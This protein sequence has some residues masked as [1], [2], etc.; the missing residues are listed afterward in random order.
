MKHFTLTEWAILQTGK[1]VLSRQKFLF[2]SL[3]LICPV[4]HFFLFQMASS[5]LNQFKIAP[6]FRF[7]FL[8][9]GG[10][11][12]PLLLLYSPFAFVLYYVLLSL[13]C[14]FYLKSEIRVWVF[15]LIFICIFWFVF[16]H[17]YLSLLTIHEEFQ[18]LGLGVLDLKDSKTVVLLIKCSVDTP[19]LFR[20]LF[21]E[22]VF[23]IHYVAEYFN[24]SV[25][26]SNFSF[27]KC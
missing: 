11:S 14:L 23:I 10:S 3:G 4:R 2:F 16:F 22:T 5:P 19:S 25:I 26:I 18:M 8:V 1:I 13:L 17:Y 15:S 9:A 20:S 6:L 27:G 7:F 24:T 21:I 12:L